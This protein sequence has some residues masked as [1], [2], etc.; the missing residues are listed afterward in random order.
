MPDPASAE[1]P[2]PR[3][4]LYVPGHRQDLVAKARAGSADAL[5]V[6][7]EDSVP[8][9]ARAGARDLLRALA[10]T[11]AV[12]APGR[13]EVWARIDPDHLDDDLDAA[14]GPG[15]R[16][17]VV[18][19]ADADV[20]GRLAP[21]LSRLEGERG[22][23]VGRTLV[24]GLVEGARALL[25]LDR[26]CRHPRLTSLGLGEADLHADLRLTRSAV[27][28]TA[29]D[30]LRLLVVLHCAAAGLAAPVAPTSTDFRDLAAFE[31]SSRQLRDLG[32]RSRTAV[33]PHQVQVVNRVFTP[34]VATVEA[35]RDV[36]SRLEAAAGAA[37]TDSS[38]R[39]IDAAVARAAHEILARARTS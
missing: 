3:S 28:A 30:A 24:V 21:G 12:D 25:E 6:D 11:G 9:T 16:G 34:D 14:V 4:F 38:G 5:I 7:L 35:A 36:V 17:L 19:K 20:L 27:T 1:Q 23:P 39:L 15:V 26:L 18:A 13:P 33:H 22:L 29:V 37:T 8:L 2:L 10:G 32:F 31:E